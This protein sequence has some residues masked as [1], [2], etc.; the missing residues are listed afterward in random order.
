MKHTTIVKTGKRV[1]P[2]DQLKLFRS[3]YASCLSVRTPTGEA[4]V[5]AK[6]VCQD[7]APWLNTKP[8]VTSHDIRIHAAKRL[9][10]YNPSAAD[11]YKHHGTI[12]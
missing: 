7:I 5:T 4:E 12:H 1:E 3:I 9:Q 2:Y 11:I 8:E 10:T 6:R